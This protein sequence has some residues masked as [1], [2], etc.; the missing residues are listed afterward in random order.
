MRISY[1]GNILTIV[2]DI[3]TETVKK[4]PRLVAKD[5]KGNEVYR[6]AVSDEASITQHGI[7]C[8]ATVDGQLAAVIVFPLNTEL[9]EVKARL[10][11]SLLL[12]AKYVPQIATEVATFAAEVDGLFQ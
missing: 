11:A 5:E 10:G 12:A 8:N 9:E 1:Q 3:D 4:N 7:T 6:V 2:I